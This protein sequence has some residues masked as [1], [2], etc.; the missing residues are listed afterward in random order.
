[1]DGVLLVVV[2]VVL[3]LVV[4]VVGRGQVEARG[5]TERWLRLMERWFRRLCYGLPLLLVLA[6]EVLAWHYRS[7]MYWASSRQVLCYAHRCVG[8]ETEPDLKGKETNGRNQEKW[9]R[10]KYRPL[11]SESPP[12]R[13]QQ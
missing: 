5:E 13:A 8:N 10:T 12:P 3:L 7:C 11:C 4:C 2:V 9:G 6:L 1:V